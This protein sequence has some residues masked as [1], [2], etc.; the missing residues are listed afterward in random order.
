MT[1]PQQLLERAHQLVPGIR[2]RARETEQLRSL[3]TQTVAELGEAGIL[4][5]LQP[6]AFGGDELSMRALVELSAEVARGCGSSGWCTAIFAVQQE[7]AAAQRAEDRFGAEVDSLERSLNAAISKRISEFNVGLDFVSSSPS[8]DADQFQ[9]FLSQRSNNRSAPVEGDPGFA[10]SEFVVDLDEL[11]ARER[12]AGRDDFSVFAPL[13]TNAPERVIITHLERDIPVMGRSFVGFDVT[14]FQGMLQPA[15]ILDT[16]GEVFAQVTTISE[17]FGAFRLSGTTTPDVGEYEEGVIYLIARYETLDGS[18]DGYI[19]RLESITDIIE[20]VQPVIEPGFRLTANLGPDAPIAVIDNQSD[21]DTY[22]GTTLQVSGTSR[23]EIVDLA[24]LELALFASEEIRESSRGYSNARLWLIGIG[25]ALLL[26]LFAIMRA[27]QARRLADAGVE[28]EI[29]QT[30]ASTDPLTGLL[31]RQGLVDVTELPDPRPGVLLFIDLDNFKS[32][33]DQ[34]GHAAGDRVLRRVGAALRQ[35]VR[36][37]DAVCRLGGDEF[38][39]FLPCPIEQE[40]I[41]ELEAEIID[42]IRSIDNRISASIGAATRTFEHMVPI[43][44][45]LRKSDAAMYQDKR[46]KKAAGR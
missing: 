31:N 35:L 16:T 45:L 23:D 25:G 32:V 4:R 27:H 6:R 22:L 42:A 39:L 28:L 26:A 13:P 44:N 29:A 18:V 1:T 41:V 20:E 33:N 15:G 2:A 19:T 46:S 24:P 14:G 8:V 9:A 11:E 37:D 10:I 43:E 5:A 17:L 21:R 30:M 40:R 12:S 7:R 3:P 38:L 36:N 34:D